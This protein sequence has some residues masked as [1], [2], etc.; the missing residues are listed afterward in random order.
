M[1]PPPNT[2][3]FRRSK[4]F[5]SSL[6]ICAGLACL[7]FFGSP[8]PTSLFRE[9]LGCDSSFSLNGRPTNAFRDNLRPEVQYITSFHG[10]GWNNQVINMM[11][12]IYLGIITDRV[13][14]L[15]NYILT[16]NNDHERAPLAF[17]DVFDIPRLKRALGKQIL[18]WRE[19]KDVNSTSLD[20]LG[21]WAVWPA[22]QTRETVERGGE[23]REN[24]NL[25]VSYTTAPAWVKLIPNSADDAHSTFWGLASLGFPSTQAANLI[26]PRPSLKHRVSLPPDH[27]LLCYDFLYFVAAHQP[28]ETG[29]DYSPAWRRA[30]Q[31]MRWTPALEQLGD[32]CVRRTLGVEGDT[33]TPPFV[34]VH[35]RHGDFVNWCTPDMPVDQCFAPLSAFARRVREVQ[36]EVLQ[37]KGIEVK[38]VIVT[39]DEKDSAWWD[40]VR[41]LGWRRPDHS[42]I[43][44]SYGGGWYPVLLD[45]VLQSQGSAFVGTDRS[46]MSMLSG[47]RVADWHDGPVRHVKW[48]TPGADD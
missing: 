13:I 42:Q 16:H 25:D 3:R 32:D 11:N 15:P 28:F 12:L 10:G 14:V 7:A 18:D 35:V 4:R 9:T 48:G 41:E 19:V 38:H 1:K 45:A 40:S 46:T 29:L 33:P 8:N 44:G 39:G 43:Y 6:A 30:G 17:G 31:L 24:L 26:P 37:R 22:V 47:R 36:A 2:F 23:V 34:S 27:H 5:I 21:C 20:D